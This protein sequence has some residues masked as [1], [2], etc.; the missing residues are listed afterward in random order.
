MTRHR[1]EVADVFREYGPQFL[2][3]YG[4][5]LSIDQIR[6]FRAILDCQTAALGGHRYL[7]PSR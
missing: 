6:V 5:S 4:G 2:D 7:P 1:L 3:Q